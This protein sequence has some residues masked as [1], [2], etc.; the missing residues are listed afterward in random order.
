MKRLFLSPIT[1][2]CALAAV[3]HIF[4]YYAGLTV[5]LGTLADPDGYMRLL[6]VEQLVESGRWT[7]QVIHLANAPYGH[8]LPWSRM[9]D[10]LMILLALPLMLIKDHRDAIFTAG[11]WI[12]PL[13]LIPC[14]V[15]LTWCRNRFKLSE[16]FCLAALALF[17]TQPA[18]VNYFI[19]AR[20]DHHALLLMLLVV[21]ICLLYGCLQASAGRRHYLAAG[22]VMGLSFWVSVETLALW[23]ATTMVLAVGWLL[24]PKRVSDVITFHVSTVLVAAAVILIETPQLLWGDPPVDR[25]SRHYL[26]LFLCTLTGWGVLYWCGEKWPHATLKHRMGMGVLAGILAVLGVSML[27]API[28]RGPMDPISPEMMEVWMSRLDEFHPIGTTLGTVASGVLT[29]VPVVLLGLPYL[30]YVIY[31]KVKKSESVGWMEMSWIIFAVIFTGLIFYQKR[32]ASYADVIWLIP[33]AVMISRFLSLLGKRVGFSLL[34]IPCLFVLIGLQMLPGLILGSHQVNEPSLPVTDNHGAAGGGMKLMDWLK[35]QPSALT[36]M[37]PLNLSPEIMYITGM[38]TVGGNYHTNPAGIT[39]SFAFLMTADVNQARQI[40]TARQ[41]DYVI[42]EPNVFTAGFRAAELDESSM[43]L[44]MQKRLTPDF[45]I[46]ERECEGYKIFKTAL[47][48]SG[49]SFQ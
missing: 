4:V 48:G 10:L 49:E 25:L 20:P 36:V 40:L 21:E 15:A 24:K 5:S 13:L 41:V 6:R 26:M 37:A 44:R 11:I 7:D 43:F 9:L 14:G 17:L 2:T 46:F 42:V 38:K 29:W 47:K 16:D 31:G 18:L 45:L 34:R 39:D 33:A 28:L 32:W 19:A 23:L 22:V 1:I 8:P 35:Q 30:G 12:S 3:L 27:A